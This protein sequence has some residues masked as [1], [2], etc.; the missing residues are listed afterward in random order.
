MRT[1]AQTLGNV[2]YCIDAFRDLLDRI[3]LEFFCEIRS[4]RRV[5][6]ASFLGV[7]VSAILGAIQLVA[8]PQFTRGADQLLSLHTW[9][10]SRIILFSEIGVITFAFD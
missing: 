4:C 2:R 5:F 10:L 1:Y 6:L 9:A 3:N 7:K 8:T